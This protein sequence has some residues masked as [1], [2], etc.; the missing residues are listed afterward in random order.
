MAAAVITLL[1]GKKTVLSVPIEEI[2]ALSDGLS[3][4]KAHLFAVALAHGM[5]LL[6]DDIAVV[7]RGESLEKEASSS[8]CRQPLS[9]DPVTGAF[10]GECMIVV[11]THLAPVKGDIHTRIA[12]HKV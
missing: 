9:R 11:L 7:L 8:F 10:I 4:L 12:R 1:E 5:G 3:A 6:D 2:P